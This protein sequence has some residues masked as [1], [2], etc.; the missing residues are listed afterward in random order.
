MSVTRIETPAQLR[1]AINK[2]SVASPFTDGFS[3]RWKRSRKTDESQRERKAVWYRTQHEHW[4]GWLRGY[5]GSGAYGRKN[6]SRSAEFVYNHI[7]NPGML[8]YLAEATGIERGRLIAAG[9][10]ALAS[11]ASMSSMSGAFRRI[12]TWNMVEGRLVRKR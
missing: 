11:R 1:R 9:K 4:L 12:V 5:E 8:V 3:S 10:A 2:L 6:W 7:V